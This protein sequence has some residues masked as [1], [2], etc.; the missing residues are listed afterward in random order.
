MLEAVAE[1]RPGVSQVPNQRLILTQKFCVGAS[2]ELRGK[3]FRH[4][5]TQSKDRGTVLG[6]TKPT[7]LTATRRAPQS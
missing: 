7:S 1:H 5:Q 6:S 3:R 4:H 2:S